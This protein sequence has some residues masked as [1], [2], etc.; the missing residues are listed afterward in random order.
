MDADKVILLLKTVGFPGA[1]AIWF[2]WK[3]QAFLDALTASNVTMVELLRQ[4]V[5]MHR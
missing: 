3:I 5:E 1:I 4:L 2:L